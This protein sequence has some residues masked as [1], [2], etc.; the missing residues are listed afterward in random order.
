MLLPVL[1]YVFLEAQV[2]GHISASKQLWLV[3][4]VCCSMVGWGSLRR[5]GEPGTRDRIAEA[6]VI[7]PALN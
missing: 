7:S 6:E 2:S 3:L 5:R 4:G 1:L